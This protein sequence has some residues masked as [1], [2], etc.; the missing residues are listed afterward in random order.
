[1][2]K[3]KTRAWVRIV[4]TGAGRIGLVADHGGLVLATLPGRI[5]GG[6]AD[7]N[8][9]VPANRPT[10]SAVRG[11]A[12]GPAG[13]TPLGPVGALL[14]RAEDALV[15]YYGHWPECPGDRIADLWRD[16][17]EVPVDLS[18]LTTFTR[19]VLTL[20][21]DIPPG[22]VISYGALAAKAGS[23]RAARAVG[24]VMARNPVP[25]FLPCHRVI[26]R[27]G[28]L[29]G[30]SGGTREEALALKGLLL[31]YEGWELPH[32]AGEEAF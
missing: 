26:A 18:G 16:L 4:N 14:E 13:G 1:M 6:E 24:A 7:V 19:K 5:N 30:F 27:D 22:M 17:R 32:P 2:G 25:I 8:D 3:E 9:R 20:L 11:G 31:R 15:E 12:A 21:R 10:W 29:G 28:T 23:P